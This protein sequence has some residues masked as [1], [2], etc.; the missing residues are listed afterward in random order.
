MTAERHSAAPGSARHATWHVDDS[1]AARYAAGTIAEP[2]AWSLEKHVEACG[3]CANRVSA[4]VRAGAAGP[5]LASLREAVLAAATPAVPRQPRPR[6]ARSSG[7]RFGRVVWSAGPALRGAWVVAV[8]LVGAGAVGLAYGAGFDGAR[9]LLLALAPLLPL[10]GVAVSYGR[11]ADPMYE[12][13]AS[14]P[15][16]GLRL[17]LLRTAAVLGVSLPLLT[18][19]GAVL[20]TAPGVPGAAAWLLPG[21]ALTIGALALGSYVGC[22]PAAGA[23]GSAWGLAVVLPVVTAPGPAGSRLPGDLAAFPVAD[24]LGGPLTQGGWAAAAALFAGLL[25]LR[26]TSFDRLEFS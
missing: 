21:L 8:V 3:K 13:S 14:T 2:D 18:A 4:A 6:P 5:A 1:L 26:R 12:I 16:G 22:R 10:A 7:G 24:Y 9:P 20:P 23:I 11:H 25:A 17:L 19:A 15:S